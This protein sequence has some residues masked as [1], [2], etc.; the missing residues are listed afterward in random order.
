V[1]RRR[2]LPP[3]VVP[4]SY[5]PGLPYLAVGD[6]YLRIY[7]HGFAE[8][9]VVPAA[10]VVAADGRGRVP[11]VTVLGTGW[12]APNL[13]LMFAEPLP[14]PRLRWWVLK[15]AEVLPLDPVDAVAV[16]A[17]DVDAARETL[18]AGGVAW[19]D[20]PTGWRLAHPTAAPAVGRGPRGRFMERVE[21]A[22]M[23]VTVAL[24]GALTWWHG[25]DW[26]LVPMLV[27]VFGY[28]AFQRW[29]G[30]RR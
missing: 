7:R 9:W 30:G 20:D 3:G 17:P 2:N 1:V 11:G 12:G 27:L 21:W 25:S 4:L 6:G 23:A 29:Y 16:T 18:A 26:L 19:V 5:V 15:P 24:I 8:Q 10:S 13:L 14:P 28:L 22:F